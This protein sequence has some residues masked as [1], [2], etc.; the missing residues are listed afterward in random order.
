MKLPKTAESFVTALNDMLADGG[1]ATLGD[2]ATLQ[3]VNRLLH[4]VSPDHFIV[5]V[6]NIEGQLLGFSAQKSAP[7][8][9]DTHTQESVA[10]T[11]Q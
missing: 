1:F 4:A 11:H 7:K 3:I 6:Q 5:T 2:N 10:P 8:A 9:N